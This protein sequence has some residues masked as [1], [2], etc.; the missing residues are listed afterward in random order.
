[1]SMNAGMNGDMN[2][3]DLSNMSIL[4]MA[5][6][7]GG[8]V[9]PALAVAEELRAM[10]ATI[11][12]LGTRK[13]IEAR[14]VPEHDFPLYW[15]SISGLRGK[16]LLHQLFI[17]FQ[18][19]YSCLQAA[20][21]VLKV[22]PDLVIGMGGF[23]TGPGGAVARVMGRR[24]LIHEQNSVAGMTNRWLSKL[25]HRVL[26]AFPGSFPAATQTVVTGNPVRAEIVDLAERSKVVDPR[27]AATAE[28]MRVLLIGGSLGALALNQ[29]M[30]KALQRIPA[31]QRPEVWHQSGPR[32]EQRTRELYKQVN[33]E[34]RLDAFVDDMVSAYQWA[35]LVVCRAGAMTVAE[36]AVAGKPALFVPY[37]YA[38]DDHQ[39]G[40]ARY[41]SDAGAAILI[42][43]GDLTDKRLAE[44]LI[45][46][47][48]DRS[49]LMAMGAKA[50]ALGRPDATTAV[51]SECMSLLAAEGGT[52]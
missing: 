39:T 37:P 16:H 40:N 9:F 6:G 27:D 20:S 8:H 36:L 12:W 5:G 41:L 51:I 24:L 1:M 44:V 2:R 32:T 30:P 18:L 7:T 3:L 45:Q 46:L 14:L 13:G 43:E 29:T 25:A 50:R 47:S 26:E 10:G 21:T 19:V 28:P 22:K 52:R 4:M 49:S 48:S 42:A 17:P 35:D 31:E 33:I 34:V 15:L 23:V 38:V 11:S